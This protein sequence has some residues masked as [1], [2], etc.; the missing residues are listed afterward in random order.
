MS[1]MTPT[2]LLPGAG[3]EAWL[4]GQPGSDRL[5]RTLGRPYHE[6]PTPAL[7]LRRD[8][9]ERNLDR[10]Q[11]LVKG[12]TR[13]RP[14]AKTHKSPHVAAMQIERGAIGI[15]TATVWEAKALADAGISDL[16]IANEIVG[17]ERIH[18]VAEIANT[19]R[20]T[21]AVDAEQNAEHLSSAAS[22]EGSTIGVLVDVDVGLGRC[23]VRTP[24]EGVLLAHRIAKL[25]GLE[26]RGVMGFEGHCT[27]EPE[28]KKRAQLANEAMNSLV[29]VAD[30]IRAIGLDVPVVSA[31]GTGTFDSTGAHASVTEL[32]AGSYAF[33][34]TSHAAIVPG[35]DLAL[36]VLA[37]VISRHGQTTI[38]DC[39]KKTVGLE[40]PAP[41]LLERNARV[42]YVAEEHTVLELGTSERLRVGDRIEVVP[43]YCPV[44][45][46]L[47]DVYFVLE[48]GIVVDVWPILA[49]GVGWTTAIG[50]G[51]RIT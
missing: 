51:G 3:F 47:H 30:A 2:T 26:L 37:T 43:S 34:D 35:F 14:H 48:D 45:V 16:L 33:M 42:Q 27:F 6:L 10:M 28:K 32:Q 39:G 31:G 7:L 24:Q 36:T 25:P 29:E 23:G 8:A 38:L 9:L 18:R 5:E 20:L 19:T 12:P 46:N 17:K 40:Q 49:R 50:R 1:I 13:L 11:G 41:A 22:S 15:T 21:V 4:A 44:V